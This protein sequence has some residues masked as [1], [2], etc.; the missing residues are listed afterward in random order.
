MDEYDRTLAD[1][2]F[3]DAARAYMRELLQLQIDDDARARAAREAAEARSACA[4]CPSSISAAPSLLGVRS[5]DEF[6]AFLVT[7]KFTPDAVQLLVDELRADLAEADAARQR[8]I[9][10]EAAKDTREAPLADV[11]RAAR[12]GRI[13]IDAYR[14]RLKRS[15][16]S[17][18]D[19]DLEIDLLVAELAETAAAR[20]RRDQADAD[21]RNKGLSLATRRAPCARGCCR[22]APTPPRP[23][24]R[25]SPRTRPTSRGCSPTK[26][27]RP[28][29]RRRAATRSRPPATSAASPS[30]PSPRPSRR[31]CARSRTTTPRS[32]RSAIPTRTPRY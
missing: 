4:G 3:D 20:K 22:S 5:V 31:A 12:L 7:Q 29:P 19:T 6:Q 30:R 18:D 13:P 10:A 21:A 25:A 2:G 23:A 16:Y 27:P 9:A 24:R 32:A 11:A 1:L 14:A 17:A 28:R 8:R 15:G 26:S